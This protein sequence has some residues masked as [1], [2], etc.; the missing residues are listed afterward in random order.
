MFSMKRLIIALLLVVFATGSI[1]GQDVGFFKPLPDNLF[2]TGDKA[3]KQSVWLF[4]PA[5]TVT[6]VALQWNKELKAF[7]AS[8][9]S[10]AGMGVGY[11]H[12]IEVNGLPYNNFGFNALVLFGVD[13]QNPS[14]ATM[15]LALT[16]NLFQ[17]LNI[18]G[19]YNFSSKTFGVL[20]GVTVKF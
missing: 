2:K 10:S 13:I 20:T 6:A 7:D 4:R 16:G 12:F 17:Y 9:L 19:L 8:A 14:P 11:N 15:S 3:V 5:V 1:L 18:G